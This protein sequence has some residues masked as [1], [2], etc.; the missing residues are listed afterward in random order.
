MQ[1]EGLSHAGVA[2]PWLDL[3]ELQTQIQTQADD[4]IE[5]VA[6]QLAKA[7]KVHPVTCQAAGGDACT[8]GTVLT[9]TGNICTFMSKEI[10][11]T[12]G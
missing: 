10:D 4:A 8:C 5:A 6:Q 11:S 12:P 9:L 2:A 7:I 3:Y 1:T